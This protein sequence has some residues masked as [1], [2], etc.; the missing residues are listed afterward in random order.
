[1]MSMRKLPLQLQRQWIER[2]ADIEHRNGECAAFADL[3]AFVK[4]RSHVANSIFGR[5]I[6]TESHKAP[7]KEKC[8]STSATS[9]RSEY[10][11]ICVVCSGAHALVNC[12]EIKKLPFY[13]RLE[14]VQS[15]QLC[16]KFLKRYYM[17]KDCKSQQ[18]CT[19]DGCKTA[20]S[21]HTLMHKSKPEPS[22][23]Q[24]LCNNIGTKEFCPSNAVFL[25]VVAVKVCFAEREER[26]YAFLDQGS[27][28]SFCEQS[29]VKKLEAT[30]VK[31]S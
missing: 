8:F 10:K 26:T 1:M 5:A 28:T 23:K 24:V 9:T 7:R 15:K 20:V 2:S 18:A 4:E 27:T 25:K 30:G 19:I 22:G 21:H 6:F 31:A 13:K 11:M 14:V 17:S 16:Y 29:L 3:S 12:E